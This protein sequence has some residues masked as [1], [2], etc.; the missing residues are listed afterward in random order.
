MNYGTKRVFKT[1]EPSKIVVRRLKKRWSGVLR[2]LALGMPD[3]GEWCVE[4]LPPRDES[5]NVCTGTPSIRPHR[6]R[7]LSRSPPCGTRIC[8]PSC[9]GRPAGPRRGLSRPSQCAWLQA[10]L[11]AMASAW[12]RQLVYASSLGIYAARGPGR[13]RNRRP[14]ARRRGTDSGASRRAVTCGDPPVTVVLV[15]AVPDP[16]R[17]SAIQAALAGHARVLAAG[18]GWACMRCRTRE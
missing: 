6:A 12:I 17:I 14:Y 8:H 7:P 9:A 16:A 10:V 4:G 5:T 18:P 1:A 2:A 15:G 3:A 13:T 11:N